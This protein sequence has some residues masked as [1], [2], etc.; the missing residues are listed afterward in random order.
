MKI[1]F[2]QLSFLTKTVYSYLVVEATDYNAFWFH[3][4]EKLYADIL[5]KC[6]LGIN[7][8]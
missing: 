6:E 3:V 7:E 5:P 2:L 1:I 8:H 4:N